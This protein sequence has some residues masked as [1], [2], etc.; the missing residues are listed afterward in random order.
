MQTLD[1]LQK[2]ISAVLSSKIAFCKFITA[3]DTGDTGGHQS[4][5]HIHKNA[6][7]LAF[8]SHGVKGSNKETFVN[9]KWQDDFQT[10]SR[11]IYYGV[12]T[13]D[14][15]RLTRFGRGFPFLLPE[16]IGSLLVLVKIESGNYLGYVLNTDDEM[17]RFLEAVGIS[18]AE[19]NRIIPRPAEQA[20]ESTLQEFFNEFILT[21][22]DDFPGTIDMSNHARDFYN[23]LNKVSENAIL[24]NSDPYLLHWIDTEYALFQSFEASR[25][26]EFLFSPL[27]SMDKLIQ[28]ANTVLQRRKSRAG[29]SLENHLE[30]IFDLH[31]LK[32][33]RNAVTENNKKP[34]FLFPSQIAYHDLTFPT[35]AL[36]V[37]GAKTT[38]KDR[39]R[40]VVNEANRVGIKFLCTIQRGNTTNQLAEMHE[41]G[42]RLVVP[43]TYISDYPLSHQGTILS[44]HEFIHM[45]RK[46]QKCE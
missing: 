38:C 20:V 41:A 45:V 9:I 42:V 19:T 35:E 32:F 43:T 21:T 3:N 30:Y 15:Y 2:A 33:E 34:D 16:Y 29:F 23:R 18:I 46:I 6:W 1:I 28:V 36:V 26:K 13:R 44:I 40:Q 12:G 14:E 24:R 22:S 4:G 37:L 25:Y 5:F 31:K 27:Q 17:E 39:W 10:T 11:F 8:D 7:P